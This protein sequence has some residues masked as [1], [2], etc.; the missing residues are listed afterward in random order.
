MTQSIATDQEKL[1][2]RRYK[3]GD[4]QEKNLHK[5]IFIADA[6]HECPVY[7]HRTPPCQSHCPSGEDIRGWLQIV[8]GIEKPP[9]DLSWQQYAFQRLS[10]SN[11]FP[12]I[13]GRVC[14]APCESKCNRNDVDDF[15]G[16]NAVE[17]FIG[18]TASEQQFA[19]DQAPPLKA[20]R[21]AII[22]GGPAGLAAAFQ[23]RKKGYAS[24]I[25]EAEQALGGLMRYGI[26]GYR[27]PRSTL[28]HEIQR[29][30]D[31]GDIE[32]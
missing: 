18:D 9:A 23:L 28:D 21:I 25:F 30:L 5:A 26:P 17:Q 15:V 6:S 24:V 14:P 13:M 8:R 7:V 2:F 12:A 16:I 22:G 4:F 29:I 11:P 27:I 10:Q 1:T 32:S 20:G 3:D 19:F 31:L